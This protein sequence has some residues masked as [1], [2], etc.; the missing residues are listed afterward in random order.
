MITS[1]T[2]NYTAR[3]AVAKSS[4]YENDEAPETPQGLS[5]RRG[6]TTG[7]IWTATAAGIDTSH[8]NAAHIHRQQ[9]FRKHRGTPYEEA[10]AA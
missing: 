9:L 7:D 2:H 6:H 5:D 4:K 1:K 10:Q 3:L 8:S